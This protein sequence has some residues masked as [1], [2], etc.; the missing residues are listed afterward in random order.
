MEGGHEIR[1]ALLQGHDCSP[2]ARC[3]VHSPQEGLVES[4]HT[5][6]D[7]A[8]LKEYRLGF[9]VFRSLPDLQK[10]LIE[11]VDWD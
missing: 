6:A 2:P 11:D 4:I 10:L 7:T 1:T 8:I 5:G 3:Y 9:E